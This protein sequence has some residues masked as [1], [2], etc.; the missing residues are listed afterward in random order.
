MVVWNGWLTWLPWEL[1]DG[2]ETGLGVVVCGSSVDKA[3]CFCR[4]VPRLAFCSSD[5]HGKGNKSATRVYHFPLVRC[6][7]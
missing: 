1:I 6:S 3:A 5:W 7:L 2:L 4:N